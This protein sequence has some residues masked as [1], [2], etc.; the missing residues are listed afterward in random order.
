MQTQKSE[1]VQKIPILG[2]IPFLGVPFRRT[3]RDDRKRELLIFLTP[4]IVNDRQGLAQTA[5]D[6]MA[7]I[8]QPSKAF[9]KKE[10]DKFRDDLP[11]PTDGEGNRGPVA[12]PIP[13]KK[14]AAVKAKKAQ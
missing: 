12:T 7:R 1:S 11:L 14:A 10:L 9:S 6:E 2:D 5:T 3:I 4:Y 8:D 13:A